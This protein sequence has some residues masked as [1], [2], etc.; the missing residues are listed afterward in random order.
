MKCKMFGKSILTKLIAVI[1]TVA[2][3]LTLAPVNGI[4]TLHSAQAPRKHPCMIQ[5]WVVFPKQTAF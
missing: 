4:L 5:L 2:V 3:V 1:T